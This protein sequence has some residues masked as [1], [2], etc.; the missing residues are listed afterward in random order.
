L[1]VENLDKK[2]EIK[3]DF[4]KIIGNTENAFMKVIHFL[5]LVIG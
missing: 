5:R 1:I 2:Y 4:D 3:E